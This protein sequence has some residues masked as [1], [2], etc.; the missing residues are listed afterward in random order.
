MFSRP[1]KV[2]TPGITTGME[3]LNYFAALRIQ[4]RQVRA[5]EVIAVEAGKRQIV[6]SRQST[7]RLGNDVV[8]LE[9]RACLRFRK[10]TLLTAELSAATDQV[11]ERRFHPQGLDVPRDKRAFDLSKSRNQP[12]CM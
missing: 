10:E 1:A 3:Q 8:E 4:P 11:L 5:L 6:G 7:V 12:R 9:W 2:F